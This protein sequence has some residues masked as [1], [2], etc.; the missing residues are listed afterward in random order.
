MRNTLLAYFRGKLQTRNPSRGP[1]NVEG[2][3]SEA[4]EDFLHYSP[5][6]CPPHYFVCMKTARSVKETARNHTD[7]YCFG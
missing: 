1:W 7:G 5:K 4:W 6:N 2:I 3:Q